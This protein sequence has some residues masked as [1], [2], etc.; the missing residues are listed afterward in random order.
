MTSPLQTLFTIVLLPLT[1]FACAS[2]I[3]PQPERN[4]K[5][6]DLALTCDSLDA[7]GICIN[8]QQSARCDNDV[9]VEEYC[10]ATQYCSLSLGH[11]S[12]LDVPEDG[13]CSDDG[14]RLY[15]RTSSGNVEVVECGEDVCSYDTASSGFVCQG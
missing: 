15:F 9:V 3:A 11:A 5:S 10:G 6:D 12:C 8:P 1:L 14:S 4:D 7:V 2:D 13:V